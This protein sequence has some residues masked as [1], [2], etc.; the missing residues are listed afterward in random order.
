MR[1]SR[2]W[3]TRSWIWGIRGHIVVAWIL[4]KDYCLLVGGYHDRSLYPRGLR[5][6]EFV[7][8]Y[9]ILGSFYLLEYLLIH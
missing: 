3:G 9:V 2:G 8:G 6:H 4:L 5:G 1:D 7:K